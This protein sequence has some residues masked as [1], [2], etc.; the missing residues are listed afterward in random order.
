[1]SIF[2]LIYKINVY[3]EQFDVK[4]VSVNNISFIW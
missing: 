2:I 1:M 4:Q 3:I